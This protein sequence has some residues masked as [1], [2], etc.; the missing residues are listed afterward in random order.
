AKADVE[1][2]KAAL[3]RS[4]VLLG[5]AR[6]EAPISGRIGKSAVTQGALVTANQADSLAAVQRLDPM[7]IDLTQSSSELLQL[8]RDLAAGT[9][10]KTEN[11]PVQILLEDGSLYKHQGKLAFSDVTVDPTT[12]SFALRITVSNPDEILLP[13]TYVRAVIG[14]G[15][16]KNAILV[17]QQG[18]ARD[19]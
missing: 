2:A 15:I 1:A 5:Y 19:P 8:R 3:Q 10:S 11:L 14:N 4:Q 18:I 17:P 13:G 6:I 12:G 16:R 7:Y 9:L